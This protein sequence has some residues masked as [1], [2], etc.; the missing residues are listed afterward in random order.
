[1]NKLNRIQHRAFIH[2]LYSLLLG[3]LG[4][5]LLIYSA[6]DEI[7]IWPFGNWIWT[8]PGETSLWRA[9]HVG[10]LLNGVMAIALVYL[11]SSFRL[12]AK[13]CRHVSISTIVMVWGNG[14]FYLFRIWGNTRGL[15]IESQQF[16][17]ANWADVAAMIAAS[18]AMITTFYAV[19]LLLIGAYKNLGEAHE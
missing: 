12:S 7:A 5:V 18:L 11:C 19:F 4:G 14:L 3:L 16:G 9:L 2:A 13:A 15:A 1:M 10:P 8:L 17:I 6:L